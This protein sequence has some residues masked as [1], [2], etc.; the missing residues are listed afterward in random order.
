MIQFC[1]LV[2]ATRNT[3][4]HVQPCTTSRSCTKQHYPRIILKDYG[5]SLEIYF[6]SEKASFFLSCLFTCDSSRQGLH[7]NNFRFQSLGKSATKPIHQ[8]CQV[9]RE[10]QGFQWQIS[11]CFLVF[12]CKSLGNKVWLQKT[13]SLGAENHERLK[14][15]KKTSQGL[16]P[17][18][19]KADE[20]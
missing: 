8:N 17:S 7:P 11:R 15:S 1:Q 13:S 4:I 9:L 14:V 10:S 3:L 16:Y 12:G 20:A 5:Q 18:K 2:G 19:K 6:G